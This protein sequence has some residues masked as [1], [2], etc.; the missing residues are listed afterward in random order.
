[1]G[2]GRR[3][4]DENACL[5]LR[6]GRIIWGGPKARVPRRLRRLPVAYAL[7]TPSVLILLPKSFLVLNVNMP[8]LL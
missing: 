3:G 7:L 6:H 2:E 5:V 8:R 4:G 1:M